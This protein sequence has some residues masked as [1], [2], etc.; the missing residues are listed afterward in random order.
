MI[1]RRVKVSVESDEFKKLPSSLIY[2]VEKFLY[3]V[4]FNK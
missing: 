3:G 2:K 1:L 4:K